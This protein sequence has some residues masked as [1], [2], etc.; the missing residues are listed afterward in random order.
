[1]LDPNLKW[2]VSE[3]KT[4]VVV[5]FSKT[6]ISRKSVKIVVNKIALTYDTSHFAF[7]I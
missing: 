1:M 5:V 6:D 2:F 7:L 4:A 3:G